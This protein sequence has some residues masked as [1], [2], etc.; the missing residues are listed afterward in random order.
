MVIARKIA[1]NVVF[2]TIAKFSST[3]LALVAI[4]FITRYLGKVGFGEYATVLAF[5]SFFGCFADLGLYSVATREISRVGADEKKI[6]GNIFSLRMLSSLAVF[7]ISPLILFLPYSN[8]LKMGI[9]IAAASFV[10]SSSYTV[11]NGVFQKNLAM[12]KVALVEVLGKVIQ[13]MIIIL[14]VKRHLGFNA[15]IMS[16]L[17]YMIFNFAVVFL[18]SRRYLK[19]KLQIDFAYWK[20]F[21]KEALPMGVAVAIT[22]LY[23]KMD[24]ILLS[25]IKSS[26]EVGIYNAAYKIIENITFFPGMIVGLTLPLTSRYIF[27][28]RKRFEDIS[29]KTFKVFLILIVPIVVGTLFLANDII[30]LIGGAGFA[31]SANVLRILIFALVFM[32]FGNFSNNILLAGNLQK[33]LMI[34]LSACAAFNII[35][36]LVFIPIYSYRGAAVVSVL[37]ELLVVIATFYLMAKNINYKPSFEHIIR[38]LFSGLAMAVVLFIFKNLNFFFLSLFSVGVYCLFL[39][40]TKAITSQE[41]LS[42]I[43]RKNAPSAIIE[44]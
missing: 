28:E 15:I 36:N 8:E 35:S 5:F 34:A 20:K 10:F 26:A 30:R 1:Y 37:T 11:L 43:A 6:M 42:I 14:A 17:I 18:W 23:F 32:F 40:I 21:I 4:G 44:Q 24:T 39:W 33:K 2:I 3:A 27:S 22:F 13:L 38:I 41:I 9:M 19:F 12:D 16:L 25:I 31:E 29:N 7:L